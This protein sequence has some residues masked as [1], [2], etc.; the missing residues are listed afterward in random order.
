MSVQD[1]GVLHDV[2]GVYSV[3][4]HEGGKEEAAVALYHTKSTNIRTC[5][6]PTTLHGLQ[7]LDPIQVHGA[8]AM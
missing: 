8:K 3:R 7:T 6:T 4:H 5:I 2:V 1:A